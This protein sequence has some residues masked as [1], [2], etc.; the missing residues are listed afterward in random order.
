MKASNLNAAILLS[1]GLLATA[2]QAADFPPNPLEKNGYTLDFSEEFDS[3]ALDRTKWIDTYLPTWAYLDGRAKAR[4]EISNGTLKQRVEQD[5]VPW[6][7]HDG[8]VRSSAF[9]TFD[10]SWV[11]NFSGTHQAN[12]RDTWYGYKTKYGYFE[13]RAKLNETGGGGHQA[14]WLVGMQDDSNDWF[15]SARTGEI[16]IL[17]TFFRNP[18]NWRIAS[19]GWRDPNFSPNW[20]L[21]DE[22]VPN[23]ENLDLTNEFHTYAMEWTK[24]GL[25]FYFDNQLYRVIK[26]APEY[27]MGMIL[28]IY[29]D[30]GSGVHN[31]VWPKEWEVDYVRVWK[32]NDPDKAVN[33]DYVRIK[34][35]NTGQYLNTEAN[36]HGGAVDASSAMPNWWS[37]QWRKVPTNDGYFM[38][39]N[40]DSGDTMGMDRATGRLISAPT[41]SG[42]EVAWRAVQVESYYRI[43]NSCTDQSNSVINTEDANGAP[44]VTAVP[45]GAWSAQ[46]S[47][48]SV[49]D[50]V[51]RS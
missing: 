9:Q 51:P 7:P 50:F 17:E 15:N 23:A 46:W 34:N 11:H 39:V 26:G 25:R 13:I 41:Y 49:L 6:S 48:D 31:E 43:Q 12:E 1:A 27:D 37:A 10:K 29:T 28:N 4:Y 38:L 44:K 20:Y 21:S 19:Y 36:R 32:K 8:T 35:R 16:D 40:R 22:K 3:T 18:H 42:C 30:A 24:G 45:N 2:S 14:W 5:Q 33:T 47:F